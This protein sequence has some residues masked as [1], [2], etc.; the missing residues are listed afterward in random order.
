MLQAVDPQISVLVGQ[1]LPPV[2]CAMN[3][4]RWVI[5]PLP[6][7]MSCACVVYLHRDHYGLLV[8]HAEK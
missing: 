7:V 1:S 3:S 4:E 5:S 2:R 6:G 8:A